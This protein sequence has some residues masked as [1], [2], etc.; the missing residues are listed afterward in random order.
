MIEWQW[1]IEKVALWK[2]SSLKPGKFSNFFNCNFYNKKN[3][4]F[5]PGAE[6]LFLFLRNLKSE[7]N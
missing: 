5:E 2:V 6:F 4:G 3:S 7:K 1:C